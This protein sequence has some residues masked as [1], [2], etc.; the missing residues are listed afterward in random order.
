MIPPIIVEEAIARGI[1]L[2]AITDHNAS[3]NVPA[4]MKAAEGKNLTVLPGIELE[5]AEEIHLVCLFP[6]LPQ[7]AKFQQI[8]DQNLPPIANNEEF[9]GIQLVVNE[10]GEF[11][12]KETRLLSTATKLS[13]E[14]STRQILALGGRF[15]PAHIEREENG[16]LARLGTIPPD[17]PTQIVEISRFTT[18][19]KVLTINP[20]LARYQFIQGGDVH[21]INDMLGAVLFDAPDNRF[22]TIWDAIT[23]S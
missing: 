7:L 6:D 14:D 3:A 10:A 2:I 20:D 9:F 15:F 4:V 12:R 22:S 13:L 18:R 1:N 19:E 21:Y 8:V 17:L 5:T 16:I 23:H 11:V